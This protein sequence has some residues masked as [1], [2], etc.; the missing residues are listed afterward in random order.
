MMVAAMKIQ[1]YTEDF[2]VVDVEKV[3]VWAATSQKKLGL[4]SATL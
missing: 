3:F 2:H 1:S 4:F